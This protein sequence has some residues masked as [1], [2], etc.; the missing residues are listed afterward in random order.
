[1]EIKLTRIEVDLLQDLIYDKTQSDFT[2]TAS[3]DAWRAIYEKIEVARKLKTK[4]AMPHVA[5]CS[6]GIPLKK[7]CNGCYLSL[8]SR[9]RIVP[10]YVE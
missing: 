1:M 6:H 2:L 10:S 8:G 3:I 5:E 4:K 9:F 7:Y